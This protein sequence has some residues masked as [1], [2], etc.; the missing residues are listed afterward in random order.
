MDAGAR[1]KCIFLESIENLK[2]LVRMRFGRE[3]SS[4]V[5]RDIVACVRQGRLFYE[6]AASSPLEIRP[7]EQFYGMVGFAKAL[8]I[9]SNCNRAS[10][11][12]QSHGVKD[13]SSGGCKISELRLKVE[14]AGTFQHFNDVMSPFARFCYVD[15]MLRSRTVALTAAN[16]EDLCHVELSLRDVLSRVPGLQGIYQLTF[17]EEAGTQA[18]ELQN[19]H[20]DNLRFFIRAD[21]TGQFTDAATLKA[22]VTRFRTRFPFMSKWRFHTAQVQGGASVIMFRNVRPPEDDEFSERLILH[23]DGFMSSDRPN[24]DL[25][26]FPVGDGLCAVGGGLWGGSHAIAPVGGHYISEFSF[27]YLAL[28]LLSSL[29][30]YRPET[31]THAIS[32]SV[33][34]DTPADDQAL[35]LIG[36]FLDL[37]SSQA[38]A[39]V[40]KVLNPREDEFFASS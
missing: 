17:S 14:N 26:P 24:D 39:M 10:T 1:H 40:V 6:A 31:W 32:H 12:C 37:N 28:F 4:A 20:F 11:L 18:L 23:G 7:L 29:V 15:Y 16:S 19:S 38:P 30:R 2:P 8:A 13:I 34:P 9:A 36:E 35:S 22:L 3:P 27:H 21:L 5:A 25:S 33:L